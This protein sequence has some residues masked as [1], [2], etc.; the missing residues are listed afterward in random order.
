MLQLSYMLF[1][2]HTKVKLDTAIRKLQCSIGV[3]CIPIPG[4]GVL[5]E[6]GDGVRGELHTGAAGSERSERQ[7]PLPRFRFLGGCLSLVSVFFWGGFELRVLFSGCWV[8][9]LVWFCEGVPI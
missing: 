5:G 2:F 8:G 1:F 4:A 6:L 7:R 9:F 3:E